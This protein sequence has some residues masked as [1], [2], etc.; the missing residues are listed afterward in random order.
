MPAKD[1]GAA[2]GPGRDRKKPYVRHSAF[3]RW[4]DPAAFSAVTLAQLLED[5]LVRMLGD[6]AEPGQY[7]ALL[8][9]MAKPGGPPVGGTR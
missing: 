9:T 5:P 6:G 2:P 3:H 1:D 7:R 8:A 4:F